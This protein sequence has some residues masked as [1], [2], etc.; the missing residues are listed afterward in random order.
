M[1]TFS[2]DLIPNYLRTRPDPDIESKYST[3]ENR[4]NGTSQ[5]QTNAHT[6]THTRPNTY[7]NTHFH[8]DSL[9]VFNLSSNGLRGRRMN[10]DL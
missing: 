1:T 7:T 8:F 10:Q 9:H 4:A 3:L 5:V 2:H 6:H